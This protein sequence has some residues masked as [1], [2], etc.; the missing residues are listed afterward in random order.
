MLRAI[1]TASSPLTS[2]HRIDS[3]TSKQR[4][5]SVLLKGRGAR[6][7]LIFG[8]SVAFNVSSPGNRSP[9]F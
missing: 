5:T 3:P 1:M 8:A 6:P 4:L 9:E 7:A 2:S